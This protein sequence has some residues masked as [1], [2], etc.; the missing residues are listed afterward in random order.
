MLSYANNWFELAKE[1]DTDT[2]NV[3][4]G[5][6]LVRVKQLDY[7]AGLKEVNELIQRLE[8]QKKKV[9][10]TYYY[11]RALCFKKLGLFDRARTDY[12]YAILNLG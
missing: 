5:L 1:F 11:L 3:S 8:G 10:M 12:E 2:E 9:D 4:F 6:A 7:E